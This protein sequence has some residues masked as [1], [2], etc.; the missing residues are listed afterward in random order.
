[1]QQKNQSQSQLHNYFLTSKLKYSLNKEIITSIKIRNHFIKGIL[2]EYDQH[3]NL[4]LE[5]PIEIVYDKNGKKEKELKNKKLIIRGDSIISIDINPEKSEIIQIDHT[6]KLDT[7]V[8]EESE[9][10]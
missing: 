2:K 9:E 6:G 1:M 3:L 5:N 8:L 4:L 10:E 7:D